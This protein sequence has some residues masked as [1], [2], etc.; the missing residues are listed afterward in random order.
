MSDLKRVDDGIQASVI[1]DAKGLNS[2]MPLF[3]AKKE[4]CKLTSG[5]ILRVDG[6]DPLSRKDL[7]GWCERSG[8]KYLGEKDMH[9][10]MSFYIKKG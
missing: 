3:R 10:Y 2:P 7:D 4:I 1:L 5:Q 9:N 6:T 8:N